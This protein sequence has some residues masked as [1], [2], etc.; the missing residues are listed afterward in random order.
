[1]D[2]TTSTQ[3]LLSAYFVIW[4]AS[5]RTMKMDFFEHVTLIRW[6]SIIMI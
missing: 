6:R 4:T 1:M 2:T 3:V 5:S